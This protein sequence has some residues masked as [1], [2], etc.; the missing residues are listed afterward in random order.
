MYVYVCMHRIYLSSVDPVHPAPLALDFS[1]IKNICRVCMY[2]YVCMHRIY[3]RVWGDV[4]VE[5]E[6]ERERESGRHLPQSFTILNNYT[7]RF[8]RDDRRKVLT[9]LDLRSVQTHSPQGWRLV[10][11]SLKDL[12]CTSCAYTDPGKCSVT[13]LLLR[14]QEIPVGHTRRP[15]V[16]MWKNTWIPCWL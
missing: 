13:F 3:I 4:Y 8:P 14:V 6:R 9:W 10:R 11:Q 2:V 7:Q 12:L 1:V 16:H 5:T 15:R